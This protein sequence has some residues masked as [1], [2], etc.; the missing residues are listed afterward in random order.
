LHPVIHQFAARL[1]A[2]D[3]QA[4]F[5]SRLEDNAVA[6][7]QDSLQRR[8]RAPVAGEC[9]LSLQET[10]GWSPLPMRRATLEA[11]REL[12]TAADAPPE[13]RRTAALL[14]TRLHWL[15]D[16][17]DVRS[18]EFSACLELAGR[19]LDAPGDREYLARK[20]TSVLTSRPETASPR[21]QAGMLVYRAINLG[22]LHRLEEAARDYAQAESLA[23]AFAAASAVEPGDHRLWARIH[24]GMAHVA[25]ESA[26]GLAEPGEEDRQREMQAQA[27]NRYLA[28]AESARLYG[29]DPAL[30]VTI[31]IELSAACASLGAWP[32]SEAAIRRAFEILD[33]VP[34][35][36]TQLQYRA[37]ILE[38]AAYVRW[39]KG[40]ALLD[41]DRP[42]D[43]LLEY[44]AAYELSQEE[45][46]RLESSA[47]S[48]TLALAHFNAGD[49]LLEMSGLPNSR[50]PEP[51]A[52]A[53]DHWRQ[54]L[55]V[56]RRLGL[57]DVEELA[58]ERL[59]ERCQA[60]QEA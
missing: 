14:L 58:S 9:L 53:C 7:L 2:P 46:A 24:L 37:L 49:Y 36:S 59:G 48:K 10:P 45:I 29:Q 16:A 43:A 17:E 32:Q 1:T 4:A 19:Y 50:V 23:Q 30:E 55:D 22:Y 6:A 57:P 47:E 35:P 31:Q 54:A 51:V 40:Q 41:E 13:D 38:T 42:D 33:R 5:R 8:Q 44:E 52:T 15:D 34:D 60:Q 12:M 3:E 28:A 39:Q 27:R 56:A 21:Q 20:I 25:M 11:L 18:E 26:E